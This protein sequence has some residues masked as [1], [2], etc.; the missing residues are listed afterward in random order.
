MT[1]EREWE[2]QTNGNPF[3]PQRTTAAL[4]AL[5]HGEHLADHRD[6]GRTD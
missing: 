1:P 6:G 2:S 4:L 5:H 3:A